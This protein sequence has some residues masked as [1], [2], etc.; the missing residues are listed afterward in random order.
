MAKL[1]RSEASNAFVF[2]G[3]HI[4][5]SAVRMALKN[6]ILVESIGEGHDFDPAAFIDEAR[7]VM[8]GLAQEANDG[9]ARVAEQRKSAWGLHTKSRGTH[10]YRDRDTGNLRRR[11]REYKRVAKELERRAADEGELLRL[12]EQSR[13]A[14]WEDVAANIA[15]TLKLVA[16]RP[17]LDDDYEQMR[18]ARMEALRHVDLSD[19]AAQ[20]KKRAKAVRKAARKAGV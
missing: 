5:E 20:Q 12:I 14:A 4:A 10:D 17:D 16:Q 15:S 9:A 18:E 11:G 3:I 8:L 2:E 6:K 7:T 13:E 19:L 1:S